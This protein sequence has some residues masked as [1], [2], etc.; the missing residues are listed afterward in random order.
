MAWYVLYDDL[1][2]VAVLEISV[3]RKKLSMKVN[4]TRL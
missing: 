3:G 2:I 1:C 4:Y